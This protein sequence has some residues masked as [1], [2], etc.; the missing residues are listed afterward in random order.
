MKKTIF[1]SV[2]VT[3]LTISSCNDKWDDHFNQMKGERSE[4]N[5]YQYIKSQPDLSVFTQMLEISGYDSILSKTQTYTVWAPVN[6]SLQTLDLSDTMTVTNIVVNH[7]SR[8][9]IP[10]AGINTKTIYMLAKKFVTFKH[11]ESGYTIGDKLLIADRSNIAVSNG[12]LHLIDGYIPY[13][14]N[15][16]EFIGKT[17]NLDSLRNYLYSQ[18][19][20]EFDINASVEIGTNDH[21]QSIYDSV[22]TFTNE[23]LDQIGYLNVEDSSYTAILPTNTAWKKAYNQIKNGYKTFGPDGLEKQRLNAQWA[24]VKNLIFRNIIHEPTAFDSIV[25]TT[26]SIFRQPAYLFENSSKS[27]LSNGIVYT[28][29]SIRFKAAESWQQ[30]VKIEAENSDFGRSFKY[31]SLSVRS[32]LGSIFKSDISDSKYLV[33]DPTTASNTTQNEV[34]FPIPNS[35]SGSY[36]IYCVFVP[37]IIVSET[38]TKPYKVSFYLSYLNSSGVSVTEAAIDLKNTVTLP[39]RVGGTFTSKGSEITKMFVTQFTFPFC[40]IIK[41]KTES[42]NITLKLKVKNDVKITETALFNRTFR[43]DYII[44]EPVK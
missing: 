35:L 16:W 33:V 19:K 23:V 31:A 29:D 44:L 32:S 10:T 8:F 38:N 27:E 24:L 5:L 3:I 36:N 39:G 11:I 17:P 15:I 18:S 22:I 6:N 12:M 30:P 4:L 41:D 2:I 9:S 21:G 43:I 28:T 1:F 40:N 14:N 7:I 26:G 42:A 37:A 13:L 20:F 25:S 34:T